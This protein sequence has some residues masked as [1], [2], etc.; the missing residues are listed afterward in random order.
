VQFHDDWFLQPGCFKSA[1][2]TWSA[3]QGQTTIDWLQSNLR[4][5]G[6]SIMIAA[7]K[8]SKTGSTSRKVTAM[9]AMTDRRA[10]P[11]QTFFVW[12]TDRHQFLWRAQVGI[13]LPVIPPLGVIGWASP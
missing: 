3:A 11:A 6:R 8:G 7:G 2:E 4:R 10:F 1:D 9:S 12:S 5:L 13:L